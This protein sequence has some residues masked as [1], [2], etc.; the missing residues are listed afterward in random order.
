MKATDIDDI[1]VDALMQTKRE[2]LLSD[3][4]TKQQELQ[5]IA[6]QLSR[7]EAY[8]GAESKPRAASGTRAKAGT[9]P[10]RQKDIIAVI[11]RKLPDGV[12][13]EDIMEELGART[14]EEK[15][16][17]YAALDRMKKGGII[18]Q[19]AKRKPY[20]LG[21]NAPQQTEHAA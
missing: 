16:P 11:T 18:Q 19:T 15:R 12:K 14:G 13:T 5:V 2:K 4:K 10:D 8:L 21:P 17:I 6:T 1:D 9:L 7:I 3:Q 20:T